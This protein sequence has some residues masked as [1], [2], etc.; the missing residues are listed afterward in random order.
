MAT[1]HIQRAHTMPLKKA[2]DAANDFAKR[3]DEKFELH[4]T[5]DGDTLHF[6][7]SGVSGTLELTRESVT[8]DLRLGF[9]LS[10]FAGTFEGHI[11]E[12]LDKLFDKPVAPASKT[13]AKAPAK[14]VKAAPA[15]KKKA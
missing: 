7:R 2:R 4:H 14:T 10:A 6:E 12:N 9:L 1:I 13:S 3:L 11:K 15:K 5:W 8:I